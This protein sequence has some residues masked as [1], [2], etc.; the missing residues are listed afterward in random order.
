[1]FVDEPDACIEALEVELDEG[2]QSYRTRLGEHRLAFPPQD[3][4]LSTDELRALFDR[5]QRVEAHQLEV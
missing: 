2:A 3:F 4:Y 5:G 1:M